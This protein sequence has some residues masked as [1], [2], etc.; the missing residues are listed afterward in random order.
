[1]KSENDKIDIGKLEKI[2]TDVN[3]LR[4][5][6]NKLDVDELN[7]ATCSWKVVNILLTI[8][9]LRVMKL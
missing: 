3:S 4:N 7:P 6:V 1:M 2:P 5:K 9:W 8:Q